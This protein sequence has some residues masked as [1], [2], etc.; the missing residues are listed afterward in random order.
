MQTLIIDKKIARSAWRIVDKDGNAAEGDQ[1]IVPLAQ[2]LEDAARY[3]ARDDVGVW[4]DADEEAEALAGLV[5]NLPV[6]AVN[7]PTFFDGRS[8]SNANIIRRK[9]GYRGELRAIGDV[10]RDQLEQMHRCGINAFQL[11]PG[12]D[13]NAA[14]A[15]LDAFTYHYQGSIDQPTPL[16]RHRQAG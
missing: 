10:R 5:E 15:Q 16:F 7:F 1:V 13:L 3:Q 6:I 11:A 9:L 4:L 2:Y 8:L 14:I 12:Q